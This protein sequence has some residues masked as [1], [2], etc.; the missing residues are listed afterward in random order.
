[1][2]VAHYHRVVREGEE[3]SL[4][5]IVGKIQP[6]QS[7]LD[8]G[9]SAGMLG[10]YLVQHKQCSVDG[11]DRDAEALKGCHPHYRCV[12]TQDLDGRSIA[13]AFKGK[14]YDVIVLADI[15]EHLVDPVPLLADLSSL[16]KPD[17]RVLLS[18]PNITHVAAAFE[19]LAG[20]FHYR[21]NGLLDSTH[22]RFYS[23]SGLSQLLQRCGLYVAEVDTV[24]R[25]INDTEFMPVMPGIFPAA[26][27]EQVIQARPDATVFQWILS[28]GTDPV[29]EVAKVGPAPVYEGYP[30]YNVRLY[31]DDGQGYAEEKSLVPIRVT[32]SDDNFQYVFTL[33]SGVDWSICKLR[34]DPVSEKKALWVQGLELHDS[35]GTVLWQAFFPS[36]DSCCVN[37]TWSAATVSKGGVMVALTDDPQWHLK[38]PSSVSEQLQPGCYLVLNVASSE[39]LIME[40]ITA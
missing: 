2:A 18:V 23:F 21:D 15:I 17:G 31:Y 30:D 14:R 11:V 26:W 7:V 40:L 39:S 25:G 16:L 35:A 27:V 10:N 37:A 33:S 4:S 5:K 29:D 8:I 20:E 36:S 32:G 38:I 3:E 12:V 24:L 34:V 22:V 6:G 13:G 28:A 9:C 19:L 1:M